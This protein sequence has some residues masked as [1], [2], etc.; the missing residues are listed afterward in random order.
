MRVVDEGSWTGARPEV[1]PIGA[2]SDMSA[3]GLESS[4]NFGC[5]STGRRIC[6]SDLGVLVFEALGSE[7]VGRSNLGVVTPTATRG[8]RF[9]AE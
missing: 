8:S 5:F 4:S 6:F 9:S 2:V 3:D 7:D 1:E